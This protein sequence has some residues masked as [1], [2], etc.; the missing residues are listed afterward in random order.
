TRTSRSIENHRVP[1]SNLVECSVQ[2]SEWSLWCLHCTEYFW[3]FARL[4]ERW[5]RPNILCHVKHIFVVQQTTILVQV[6]SKI[7]VLVLV[8]ALDVIFNQTL[9]GVLRCD[10]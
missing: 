7:F 2:Y 3:L 10:I 4:Q 8:S 9:D 5:T 1:W 6:H